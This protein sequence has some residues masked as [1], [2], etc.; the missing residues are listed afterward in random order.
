MRGR[1]ARVLGAAPGSCTTTLLALAWGD[2]SVDSVVGQ[3]REWL[4]FWFR[5]PALHTELAEVWACIY[6]DM[7]DRKPEERWRN[8]RGP[9]AGIILLRMDCAWRPCGLALWEDPSG[10]QW[11]LAFEPADLRA[12]LNVVR[13]YLCD[14]VWQRAA[15]HHLGKGL[16]GGVY[17]PRIRQRLKNMRRKRTRE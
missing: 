10:Q 13:D 3:I 4:E 15:H 8:A 2:L 5:N 17:L 1:Q 16:E 6:R 14:S 12:F 9:M 11:K 7:S